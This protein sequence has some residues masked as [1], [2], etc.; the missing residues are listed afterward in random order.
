[1]EY[2]NKTYI[3]DKVVELNLG[4]ETIKRKHVVVVAAKNESI[5]AQYLKDKLGFEGSKHELTWLMN[6]N[7]TTMYDQTG[8]KELNVQAKILYNTVTIMK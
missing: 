6:T 8:N 2:P 7:H 3:L 5:A 1:M 4:D